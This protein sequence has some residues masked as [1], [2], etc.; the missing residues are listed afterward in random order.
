MSGVASIDGE[1]QR[2]RA[3]A[4]PLRRRLLDVLAEAGPLDVRAL[5]QRIGL[6]PNGARRH[7]DALLAAGLVSAA[8]AAPAGPGRPRLLYRGAPSRVGYPLL[9]DMLAGA[10]ARLGDAAAVEEE[11]RRFGRRLVEPSPQP[12][13]AEEA[14]SRL[15]AMLSDLGF[16]PRARAAAGGIRVD[17]HRCPFLDTA[18]AHPGVV[19][20]LHL[21]LMQGALAELGAPLTAERLDPLVRPSLCV[22]HLRADG[23]GG[24]G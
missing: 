11:G 10:V 24:G 6:S 9:A 14:G 12:P 5:A 7:L 13:T 19:C 23:G 18:R 17:I 15:T 20:S 22:G 4:H 8:P 1:A 16:A 3:L 2:H 21:G